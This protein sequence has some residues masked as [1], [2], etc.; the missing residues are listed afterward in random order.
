MVGKRF[1]KK[2]LDRAGVFLL[3]EWNMGLEKDEHIIRITDPLP[4]T[5]GSRCIA[6]T[7]LDKV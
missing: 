6:P 1:A 3:G 2:L 7:D 5:E 4:F